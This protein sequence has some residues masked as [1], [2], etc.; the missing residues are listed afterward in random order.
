[1]AARRIVVSRLIPELR[2]AD[3]SIERVDN[4]LNEEPDARDA[5]RATLAMLHQ[6]NIDDE[7]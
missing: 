4:E 7:G 3:L 5:A 1:M 6:A 2:A